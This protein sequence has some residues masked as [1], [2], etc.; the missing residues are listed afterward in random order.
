MSF[1]IDTCVLSET[2]RP[3]PET[4][5]VGWLDAQDEQA[6]FVSVLTLGEIHKGI[7]KLPASPRKH[8][9]GDW[10]DGPLIQRF[11]R[12]L[13]PIDSSVATV[14]GEITGSSERRGSP[15]PV[16]DSLI[17]ATARVH[18]LTVVTRNSKHF[19]QCEVPVVDPWAGG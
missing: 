17:A 6:L 12:R 14:W 11:G 10:V 4:A 9:L 8:L 13:L 7:A 5:V 2:V 15:V 19:A 16:I 3:R 18:G 1:L